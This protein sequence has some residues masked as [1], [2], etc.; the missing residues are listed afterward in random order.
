M[1]ILCDYIQRAV[2]DHNI[3]KLCAMPEWEFVIV[4]CEGFF[5]NCAG[6]TRNGVYYSEYQLL[7]AYHQRNPDAEP[8]I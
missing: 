2:N 3:E 6:V 4:M 8:L 1:S 5:D 7:A